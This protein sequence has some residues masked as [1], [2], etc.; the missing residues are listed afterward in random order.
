MTGLFYTAPIIGCKS[1]WDGP[2]QREKLKKVVEER[3]GQDV[4]EPKFF[5]VLKDVHYGKK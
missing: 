3:K 4:K 1:N 2:K 5:D